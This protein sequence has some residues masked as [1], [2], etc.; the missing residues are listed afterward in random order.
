M[1]C[2]SLPSLFVYFTTSRWIIYVEHEPV[3]NK[4]P[5]NFH[6]SKLMNHLA[7]RFNCVKELFSGI[8]RRAI[9]KSRFNDSPLRPASLS[10]SSFPSI[11]CVSAQNSFFFSSLH[12]FI[13][14][15]EVYSQSRKERHQ[16]E[17]VPSSRHTN[18]SEGEIVRWTI[19]IE[20]IVALASTC[21]TFAGAPAV[22]SVAFTVVS[23]PIPIA[24]A[25]RLGVLRL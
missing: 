16:E 18:T 3:H 14:N 2:N 24:S 9:D 25:H 19:R 8:R 4:F 5:S 17:P 22:A 13:S 7:I 6:I 21:F 12:F 15:D 10:L 1:N 20:N 23:L 11:N